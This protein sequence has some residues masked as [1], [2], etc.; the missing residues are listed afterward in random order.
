MSSVS[1]PAQSADVLHPEGSFRHLPPNR[2]GQRD[3]RYMNLVLHDG[4]SNTSGRAKMGGRFEAAWAEGFEASFAMYHNSGSGTMMAG[5]LTAAVGPGDEVIHGIRCCP[6]W[7]RAGFRVQR[8][9][10]TS[11]VE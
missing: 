3:R 7:R 2:S 4:F 10:G 1:I 5:L 11:V 6:M 9:R 8:A